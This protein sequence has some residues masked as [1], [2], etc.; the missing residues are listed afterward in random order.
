MI[1]L[2]QSTSL[3]A[4]ASV[5]TRD[6][7]SLQAQVT[8]LQ[9]ESFRRLINAK[10]RLIGPLMG[11]SLVFILAVSLLSGY[12]HAFMSMKIAGSFNVGYLLVFST[13]VLCWIV[14]IVYVSV[15]NR[16]FEALAEDVAAEAR[17]G[18]LS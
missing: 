8:V 6:R 5:R 17:K 2:S 1:E 4:D 14:S 13:Y 9:S 16:T 11:V 15:A 10:R 7:N 3:P 12:G 18:D